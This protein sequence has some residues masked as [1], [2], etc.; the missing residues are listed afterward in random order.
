MNIDSDIR[1]WLEAQQQSG[2]IVL[3]P[4]VRTAVP[5][6]IHYVVA[7]KKSGAGGVSE[8]RQSGDLRAAPE[9]A[10]PIAQ[11]SVRVMPED[12]CKVSIALSEGARVLG[13]Y[14]FLCR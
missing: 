7:M 9:Q 3:V 13:N 12:D 2:Q 14:R 4:Y 11:L 6:T 5:R 10:T 1:V 8:T